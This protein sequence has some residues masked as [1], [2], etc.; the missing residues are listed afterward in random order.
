MAK[1]YSNC[2]GYELS[3]VELIVQ[4]RH[5]LMCRSL[6]CLPVGMEEAKWKNVSGETGIALPQKDSGNLSLVYLQRGS[7]ECDTRVFVGPRQHVLCLW[8]VVPIFLIVDRMYRGTILLLTRDLSL[9][10][11]DVVTGSREMS[12]SS[13]EVG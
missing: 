12:E 4:V 8:C 11:R 10:M 9:E 2:W 7:C 3:P 5:A 13:V 1:P 6:E